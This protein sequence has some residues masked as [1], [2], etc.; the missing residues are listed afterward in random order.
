MTQL[1]TM[2]DHE[3]TGREEEFQGREHSAIEV[4]TTRAAQEVQAAMIVAQKFPRDERAAYTR[5]MRACGRQKLAEQAMYAYPRGGQTVTGPSIRLAEMLA[6]NWGNL[7]FGIVELEQRDGESIIMSYCWD[8]ETNTRQTKVFTVP[9]ER[10]TR[11]GVTKLTDPRDIYEMTANQG[12]RRLRA[13]ILGI[14][15][16]DVVE[17][18]CAQCEQTVA[19]NVKE[20]L[21]DRLRAMVA[22]F[23]EYGVAEAQIVA[24]LGHRLEATTEAELA[25]LRKVYVSLRDNMASPDS[26]FPEKTEPTPTNGKKM[27]FGKGKTTKAAEAPAPEA[28]L[29]LDAPPEEI[30]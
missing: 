12:A 7:D 17:A 9:H 18:A 13:C 21:A 24:R 23:A 15:P 27:S 16:G 30:P 2:P 5:I 10:H 8:L 6:Q 25:N 19:G 20:P 4:A 22:A 3:L 29:P 26:F 14:I 28:E 11:Q 1:A